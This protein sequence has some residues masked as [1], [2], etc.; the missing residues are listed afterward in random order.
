MR[1]IGVVHEAQIVPTIYYVDTTISE[2]VQTCSYSPPYAKIIAIDQK[3]ELAS[4]L[5]Y[6][7]VPPPNGVSA[8]GWKHDYAHSIVALFQLSGDGNGS[9][10][11]P[12][13][14]EYDFRVRVTLILY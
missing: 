3:Y 11:R 4:R 12:V 1:P 7:Y 2:C 14:Y 10:R 13:Q 9:L 5:G 6:S 8:L